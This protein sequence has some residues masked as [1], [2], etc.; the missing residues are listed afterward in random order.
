[1][2][3]RQRGK[4]WQAD[5][6]LGGKRYRKTHLTKHDAEMWVK[7][8]ESRFKAGQDVE[9]GDEDA[10]CTLEGLLEAT[11]ARYWQGT[12]NERHAVRNAQ[13]MIEHLGPHLHPAVV[14]SAM[15]D[16]VVVTLKNEMGNSDGTINRKIASLRKM[17]GHSVKLGIR[18]SIPSMD[19]FK[20][21]EGRVRWFTEDEESLLIASAASAVSQ[22]FARF[23]EV[24]VDTGARV[25]EALRLRVSDIEGGY[26]KFYGTKSGKNRAIPLTARA[27]A[28][29][30]AM[31][32]HKQ[33]DATV[34]PSHW[35]YRRVWK[36]WVATRDAAKLDDES[37][38]L[39]SWRHTFCT[40]LLTR[41]VG[42]RHVQAL[43]GHSSITTTLRYAH[44]VPEDLDKAIRLLESPVTGKRD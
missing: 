44:L 24:L 14:T 12:A 32:H 8:A 35:N 36:M 18:S 10:I 41:G 1:M 11:H 42:V 22:D 26:A 31:A 3:V 16:K 6:M 43:A 34:F 5:A 20:E 37:A 33:S 28:A 25:S 9:G 4:K 39:H 27:S 7:T 30:G 38:V 21:S 2:P 19:T 29:L 13:E 23:L 15:V 40:R 17:M